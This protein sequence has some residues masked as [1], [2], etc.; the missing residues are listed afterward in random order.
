MKLQSIILSAI[1]MLLCSAAFAQFPYKLTVSKQAYMPLTTGTDFF[2][3]Y[4]W[5][6]TD[7]FI[8]PF[9]FNFKMDTIHCNTF[10]SEGAT[11]FESDTFANRLSGLI[12]YED[13]LED[14]GQ[15]TGLAT[16]SPVRY[17]VTG[18]APNRIFKME[19]YNA[20]FNIERQNYS[21][22]N[23]SVCVQV[24]F[25]ESSNVFEVRYGPSQITHAT[26]Y[27]SAGSGPLFA[28]AIDLDTSANGKIYEIVGSPMSPLIDSV[29]LANGTPLGSF[30]TLD[31]WPS[32]SM[33][34]TFTPK[35]SAVHTIDQIEAKIFP[36]LCTDHIT[37]EV[38]SSGLY[39]YH[40][41][42][43]SGSETGIAGESTLQ[44]TTVDV[45][46]LPAG[47]Y[48]LQMKNSSGSL[49]Q[50]FTKL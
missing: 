40:I 14:R 18:T 50:R 30:N 6:D 4:I 3:G 1:L 12:F 7:V 20:G 26:D 47:T 46:N 16:L 27:F 24:W 48:L 15:Q 44:K 36:T 2:P 49:V 28:Y 5:S 22:M 31:S 43:I 23:D 17:Q 38:P 37:L 29:R 42:T 35:T 8:A 41:I 10:F 21:T 34:Y 13:L 25:Y 11:S 39:N 32:D 9:G 45:S 19:V 33:V